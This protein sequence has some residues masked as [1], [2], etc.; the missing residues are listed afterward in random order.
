MPV[1][2]GSSRAQAAAKQISKTPTSESEEDKEFNALFS[3]V[4]R[5]GAC[6]TGHQQSE[7]SKYRVEINLHKVDL[8]SSYLC[9][10]LNINGLT[11]D[12]ENLTTFF[13]G[14]IIGPKYSFIT[15]KWDATEDK[16]REHWE[17]FRGFLPLRNK[18]REHGF[19]Y[20]IHNQNYVFMR[21]KELFL[22]PDYRLRT[23]DGASFAGFYYICFCLSTKQVIGYYYHLRS[24]LFQ[25]LKLQ[26]V[27]E[28][29]IETFEFC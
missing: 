12:Y 5:D 9:G 25:E 23:I 14:E 8:D 21:W 6:F 1:S 2:I 22:V 15:S 26:W 17:K 7:D 11:E 10:Y 24:E 18:F 28:H 13:E 3:T 27:P 20:D 4:L 29:S 19:H 16:D